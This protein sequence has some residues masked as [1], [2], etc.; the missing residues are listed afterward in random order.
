MKNV[1]FV[2]KNVICNSLFASSLTLIC[3]L[4]CMYIQVPECMHSFRGHVERLDARMKH[5]YIIENRLILVNSVF[6]SSFIYFL[7]LLLNDFE[8]SNY[9]WFVVCY[10]DR[11]LFTLHPRFLFCLHILMTL[12]W[13]A[14][15]EQLNI[16]RLFIEFYVDW[17]ELL[18]EDWKGGILSNAYM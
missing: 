12:F 3:L 7:L 2:E 13:L 15:C 10:Y 4:C 18:V 8:I 6:Q 11:L 16:W 14:A 1:I 9:E 5:V 17:P